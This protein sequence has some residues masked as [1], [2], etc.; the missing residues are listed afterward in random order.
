[1]TTAAQPGSKPL[2]LLRDPYR[3]WQWL[4]LPLWILVLA[5]SWQLAGHWLQ[6]PLVE[7]EISGDFQ[8][9]DSRQ[10]EQQL[11]RQMAASSVLED[12]APLKQLLEQQDWV[13]EVD[14]QRSWPDLLRVQVREERPVARW[15]DQG[16]VNE[17]GQV[18]SPATLYSQQ[19]PAD[20]AALPRLS[21]PPQ[22]SKNLMRQYRDFNQILRP[23]GVSLVG[24]QMEARGAWILTL[25]KDIRLL[26][27]RGN[28]IEKLRRFSQVYPELLERYADR[29]DQIDARYTNGLAVTWNE[30]PVMQQQ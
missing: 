16:L 14:L 17:Q 13:Y 25:D 18:F 12:L 30:P 5:L 28:S 1:M 27:G 8:Q 24:L 22:H 7:I 2:G 20:F 9:L 26:I 29:I 6:R 19:L 10:L 15:G 11:W 21:G 23:L 3:I 4:Q